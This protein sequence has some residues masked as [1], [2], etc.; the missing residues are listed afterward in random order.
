[1]PH[2]LNVTSPNIPTVKGRVMEKYYAIYDLG[3]KQGE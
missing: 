1:M 2:K 3:S